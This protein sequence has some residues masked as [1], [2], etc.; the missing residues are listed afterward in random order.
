MS[1][2]TAG[3]PEMDRLFNARSIAIVGASDDPQRI[4]G[5]PL[6]FLIKSGYRGRI[7]PVNPKYDSVQGIPCHRTI[8]EIGEPV[9]TAIV[10]VPAD[11]VISAIR[12]LGKIGAGYAVIF[13]AGFAETGAAGEALQDEL[14]KT[15]AD[16]GIRIVGPNTLGYSSFE[17]RIVGSFASTWIRE[18]SLPLADGPVS[19]V[20]H[21]GAFGGLIYSMAEDVGLAFRH[22]FNVGNEADVTFAEALEYIIEDDKVSAVGGYLEGVK[23]GP[24]FLRVASRANELGKPL[25]LV[26]VGRSER[27]RLAVAS[28]TGT[29]V[30]SDAT[31]DAV[32]R[33]TN[34]IRVEDVRQMLDILQLVQSGVMPD[35]P[36]IAVVSISGGLGV[37]TADQCGLLGLRMAELSS[38]T[39]QFLDGILP[40]YGSSLN[41]I[42][43]TAQLVNDPAMLRSVL[44]TVLAD[45]GVDLVYLAMGLQERAGE[46]FAADVI[47]AARQSATPVIVSWVCGPRQ[48]YELFDEARLPV[49]Q[50]F[51]RPLLALQKLAAWRT[52]QRLLTADVTDILAVPATR[53]GNAHA[54]VERAP[55]L[56]EDEA[57]HRLSRAGLTVP[58]SQPMGSREQA[59][60]VLDALSGGPAVLKAAAPGAIVHKTDLGLVQ[61]G[62]DSAAA[63][64]ATFDTLSEAARRHLGETGYLF[65]EQQAPEGVDLIVSLLKDDVFG[66]YVVLGTGGVLVELNRQAVQHLAPLSEADAARLINS[67]PGLPALLAGV[68]GRRPSDTAALI[69]ALVRVSNIGADSPG[70]VQLL[71]I[72]PLRV[73]P[74][75]EG[76]VALDAVWTTPDGTGETR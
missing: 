38:H 67:V 70:S 2:G 42:D 21:S 43:A 73:L 18:G 46:R 65:A 47:E 34:V 55:A 14:A 74:A 23:D 72:N 24:H 19:F 48:L 41:P 52:R 63:L 57:K 75:G 15:A 31:Y 49:F 64:A 20:T 17:S 13:S 22:F 60:A 7:H 61:A 76:A 33:Q 36:R 59:Q 50:D 58:P 35:D 1:T 66:W 30:G 71:E 5:R 68:R 3:S 51:Y 37:W 53:A 11:S 10:A 28:H 27:S 25:V 44:R 26:K 32:F 39:R 9:D 45:P 6:D 62:L 4:G 69:E 54:A 12:D 40:A 8:E 29:L 16:A 56:P